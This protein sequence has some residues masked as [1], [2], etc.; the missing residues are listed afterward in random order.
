MPRIII[1]LYILFL[2]KG[3]LMAQSFQM[4]KQI[5]GVDLPSQI[6]STIDQDKD[7]RIWFTTAKGV[8]YSDGISTYG[9]PEELSDN[10]NGSEG[11]EVDDDG[12]VWVYAK[13]GKPRIYKLIENDWDEYPI[14][15]SVKSI[16]ES[17]K[18]KLYVSGGK[19]NKL[20]VLSGPEVFASSLEA[21]GNWTAYSYDEE[22]WGGLKSVFC[23]T[24]DSV[25]FLFGKR[26]VRLSKGK[27]IPFVFHNA[28][29]PGPV[30]MV[31]YSQFDD[32]FYFLGDDYLAMGNS[33]FE[34]ENV[35]DQGFSRINYQ[36]SQKFGLQTKQGGVYYFFNSQL[37]KY[38]LDNGKIIEISTYD[39]LKSFY[40]T[41]S[42]VDRENIIWIGTERGVVNLPTLR[43]QNYS[44]WEGLME[45][46]VS[47][48]LT[49]GAEEILYGFNNGIQHWKNGEL[50]FESK[51]AGQ[52]GEPK[53]RIT[54]FH[55]DQK[56]VVWM[57]SAMKGLGRYD[58]AS[59]SLSYVQA[60]DRSFVM[61]AIPKGDSLIIV[62]KT[63]I[64][65]SSIHQRGSDHFKNEITQYL[66]DELLGMSINEVRKVE[67]TSE[68][69]MV[70]MAGGWKDLQ[71]KVFN[72]DEVLAFSGY[73]W[74][75]YKE[76][77]LL[78]TYDGLKYYDG[79]RIVPYTL[80]GQKVDRPVY[81]VIA[82]GKGNIWAGTD[83][84][85]AIIGN[86]IIRYFNE[87]NGLV[88]NEVNRGAF[89]MDEQGRV[90]IGTQNGLSVFIPEED[91]EIFVEPQ[92]DVTSL[93][94]LGVDDSRKISYDKIPYELNNVEF[95]FSAISFLQSANFTV[96]YM[97]EGFHDDWQH[98]QNPRTNKLYF[99]NLPPGDYQLKVKASLGGQFSSGIASSER[100]SIIKPT[101]LQSWFIG[102][103]ILF[104]L[105]LG[106]G[107]NVLITQFKE[108]GVLQK[109]IAE[110]NQEIKTAED[111]FKNVWESSQDG[112]MLLNLKGD[113][114]AVNPS[115]I[116]LAGMEEYRQFTGR[117]IKEFFKKPDYYFEHKD[118]ILSLLSKSES[119]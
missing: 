12:Q 53:N 116:K 111:Q 38:N 92:V 1:I 87:H 115:M 100:F 75:R 89:T 36:F 10:L 74:I 23:C 69:R 113:V 17:S 99:N 16:L 2:L 71:D 29:L 34:I 41:T 103:L 47:A 40:I 86:G 106:F 26:T 117:H 97:L 85:V 46:E 59:R 81:A 42:F 15:D 5:K 96:S 107:L 67:F 119:G 91:D 9:L 118:L 30:W 19:E 57:S 104:L 78:A 45:H 68:G 62:S 54:T 76:G 31:R 37:Y 77:Y 48:V 79:D 21:S 110:K 70:I 39:A 6:V 44:K 84:G 88:G 66:F 56:G 51:S 108:Q 80:N 28:D 58:P 112:F 22:E 105:M 73:D 43:F 27:F 61:H 32:K 55:V 93:K 90:H 49:L 18:M 11:V 95:E 33:L 72:N 8:F 52:E 63:H 4:N 109:S 65:L 20:L 60:P 35:L 7:G 50:I 64:Y 102:A 101:Y 114:L 3:T 14:E 98:V 25:L 13:K 94:V 83:E 24:A 82:D